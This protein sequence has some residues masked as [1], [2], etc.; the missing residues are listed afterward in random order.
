VPI[1]RKTSDSSSQAARPKPYN[2]LE[3]AELARSVEAA[4]LTSDRQPL[5]DVPEFYGVGIYVLYY[6]GSLHLYQPISGTSTPIY[7]GK[8]V[9]RGSRKALTN[10]TVAGKELWERIS[11]HRESTMRAVDLDSAD[12]MVR[13][14]VADDVFIPLGERLMIR[15]FAPVW[16]VIVDGFG[17]HDPGR[18][19]HN[20]RVSP[21]D[22][23]HPG[24][25]WVLRLTGPCRFTREE[26]VRRVGDHFAA[27]PP[28]AVE[29][30]LPPAGPVAPLDD[31]E[32]EEE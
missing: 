10:D 23:L 18:G 32:I 24:R 13:Y 26:I 27:H 20:Q 8:A 31:S 19:R 22:A 11:E 29:A 6:C 25:P 30:K 28:V 7:V 1:P 2:P 14:L 12:F 16:N 15:T 5:D 17:N 4:L 3:K 21:W 9:P